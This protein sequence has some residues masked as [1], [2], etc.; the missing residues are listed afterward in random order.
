MYISNGS[1]IS[2]IRRSEPHQAVPDLFCMALLARF[3]GYFPG[4]SREI[5]QHHDYLSWAILKAHTKNRA[6]TVTLRSSDPRD[7]PRVNFHHF[8]E[9][10]DEAGEDL[11]AVIAGIRFVRRL[12]DALNRTDAIAIE[13]KPGADCDT[14]DALATYVRDNAWGHHASCSCA[15]GPRPAGGVLASDF[16]VHGTRGLRVVDASVFPR[17]P[18]YFIASAIYIA[19]E[20]AADVILSDAMTGTFVPADSELPRSSPRTGKTVSSVDPPG[21]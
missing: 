11:R 16:T 9:G 3:Y 6:G 4:Y 21:N 1:A 2:V 5:T 15:I 8:E 17:I 12:T 20:K 19:A 18:G 10:N 14:E 7:T 13:E